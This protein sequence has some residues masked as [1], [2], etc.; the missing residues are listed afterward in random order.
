MQVWCLLAS[1]DALACVLGCR[2]FRTGHGLIV[3]KD[4]KGET[5][6]LPSAMH[7]FVVSTCR[8]CSAGGPVTIV[9]VQG[10]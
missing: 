3:Q 5:E 1:L 2:G 8:A 9:E 10:L 6:M 4:V 7:S